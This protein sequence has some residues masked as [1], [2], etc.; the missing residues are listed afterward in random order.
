MSNNELVSKFL[1]VCRLEQNLSDRTLKAY[2]SD[3]LDLQTS[4]RR[5]SVLEVDID[6]VRDYL[7]KLRKRG[8]RETTVKRRLAT[9][10]VFFSY[11]ESEGYVPVSPTSKMRGRFRISRTLPKVLSKDDV[12]RLL[13]QACKQTNAVRANEGRQ[14]HLALRNWLL[15]ELL[16]CTGIRTDELVRL[17]VHDFSAD[18]S[19][20]L[21]QGKGRKE[22][23]LFIVNDEVLSLLAE[24]LES[25]ESMCCTT[26]GLFLNKTGGRLSVHSVGYIFGKLR[27]AAGLP[28]YFTPHCLRH[29]MATLLIENGADL[30]SVQE[31]LGHSQVNTTEIYVHVSQG[32]RREVIEKFN[33]RDQ[34]RIAKAF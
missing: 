11:L 27:D 7:S 13:R 16:F 32:R 24:Y 14:R 34:L 22:R 8:L 6:N 18:R 2:R 28:R 21:I 30:R 1:E 31:I 17:N 29:T 9:L 19:S 10:K 4:L 33:A 25:R 20:L 15:V 5:T 26:R 3:L 12:T 23:L